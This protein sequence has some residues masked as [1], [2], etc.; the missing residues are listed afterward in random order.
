MKIVVFEE[1]EKTFKEWDTP[2]PSFTE[3]AKGKFNL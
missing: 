2:I 1:V 3:N